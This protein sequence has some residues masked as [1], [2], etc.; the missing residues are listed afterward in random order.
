[1]TFATSWYSHPR[2]NAKGA[3]QCRVCANQGGI[4][5][6]YGLDICRQCFRERADQIGFKKFR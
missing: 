2:K 4:I 5:R 6:K 3:R 1:M